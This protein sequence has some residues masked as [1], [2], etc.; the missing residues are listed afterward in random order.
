[1][2]GDGAEW[3]ALCESCSWLV[4]AVVMGAYIH[5]CQP[6]LPRG[7][8]VLVKIVIGSASAGGGVVHPSALS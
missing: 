6:P 5:E 3:R 8:A 7:R 4:G 1:M 2:E